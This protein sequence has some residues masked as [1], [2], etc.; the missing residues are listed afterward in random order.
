MS[1]RLFPIALVSIGI[2]LAATG[3]WAIG[4]EATSD[5]VVAETDA[6]PAGHDA[7]PSQPQHSLRPGQTIR[8]GRDNAIIRRGTDPTLHA[9]ADAIR[10]SRAG[11]TAPR[12]AVYE[13]PSRRI[14]RIRLYDHDTDASSTSQRAGG[15]LRDDA[16]LGDRVAPWPY[17]GAAL[18]WHYYGAT[19]PYYY[20]G[21]TRHAYTGAFRAGRDSGRRETLFKGALDMY[22]ERMGNPPVQAGT[23]DGG[24]GGYTY[25]A[26]PAYEAG[27]RTGRYH[28]ELWLARDRNLLRTSHD[29]LESG[30]LLFKAGKYREALDKFRLAASSDHGSAPARLL[31]G[32]AYFALGRYRDAARYI[33]RAFELQPKI[34]Y[35]D[36]D[37][38]DDYDDDAR[39]ARQLDALKTYASK[40]PR[41]VD[42]WLLL[43]YVQR[44]SG[45]REAADAAFARAYKIAPHDWLLRHLSDVDPD[46]RK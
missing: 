15:R 32:H 25:P 29:A 18:P 9:N 45:D 3:P 5:P 13:Y 12:H 34:K 2:G 38:R 11:V 41:D 26:D 8:I 23:P 44:F 24:A 21:L 30:T 6:P 19:L 22:N 46:P 20:P 4:Q 1:R 31:V 16:R 10:R 36:F 7:T 28:A 33:R 43:G 40:L 42:A 27:R 37:I 39:F 35:V 14:A 17:Y